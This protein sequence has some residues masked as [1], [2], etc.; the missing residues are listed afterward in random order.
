MYIYIYVHITYRYTY[1]DTNEH[2]YLFVL[3]GVTPSAGVFARRR[4]MRGHVIAR[5]R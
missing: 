4:K 3:G 2:I 5:T 1:I